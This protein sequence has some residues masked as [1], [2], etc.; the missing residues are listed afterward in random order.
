[1]GSALRRHGA[2]NPTR[3]LSSRDADHYASCGTHLC[4]LPCE[5]SSVIDSAWTGGIDG[6]SLVGDT[7]YNAHPRFGAPGRG[8]YMGDILPTPTPREVDGV[9][10]APPIV[11][12]GCT[13][14]H[15]QRPAPPRGEHNAS[16]IVEPTLPS[17][18]GPG[19]EPWAGGWGDIFAPRALKVCRTEHGKWI[20]VFL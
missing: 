4:S 13:L 17:F 11:A 14:Y 10:T 19:F 15:G 12:L 16:S 9:V 18:A 5:G 2:Q 8:V 6:D 20:G 7:H 3:P 1:M